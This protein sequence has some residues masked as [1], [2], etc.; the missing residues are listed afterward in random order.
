MTEDSV[1]SM[2]HKYTRALAV[3]L[4]Y[5]DPLTRLHSDRVVALAEELGKRCGLSS[6]ELEMLKLGGAFHD[7][8]KIGVEDR[9]LMKKA[10]LDEEEWKKMRQHAEIGEKILL[11]VDLEG[12][13]Q[14]ARTV[15]HHHEHFDGTGY[16]DGLAGE[17]IPVHARIISLVDSYDAMAV[18][19][20]YH[21]ARSHSRIMQT[22]HQETGGKHDPHLMRLFAEVIE[23]S[24]L[25]AA[26]A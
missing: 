13:E 2:L 16:P 17:D 3:A 15:R 22:L 25:K 4:C 11:A 12:V 21:H 18:T 20:S 6:F 14:A 19:R 24:G 23:Q 10:E 9:I 1:F 26:E 5:R 8:G 7:V